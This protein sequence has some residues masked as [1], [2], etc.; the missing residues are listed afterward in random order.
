M[1]GRRTIFALCLLLVLSAIGASAETLRIGLVRCFKGLS[2]VSVSSSSDLVV[3]DQSGQVVE[4]YSPGESVNLHK[5]SNGIAI[6][7]ESGTDTAQSIDEVDISSSTP[8]AQISVQ[9]HKGNAV[10]YRGKL[11]VRSGSDGL[12]LVNVIELEDYLLGVLP[13]EMPSEFKPEAVKAQSVAA[14]TYAWAHRGRHEKQGYDLC[15]CTDCQV[16]L[17]ASGEKPAPSDAVKQ[18]TGLVASY[19]GRLISA[20]YSSDCGGIT[21]CGKEQYLA[22][23]TDRGDDGT[24]YCEHDG[25]CWSKSWTLEDFEKLI[26]KAYPNIKGITTVSI[27][28]TDKSSRVEGIKIGTGDGTMVISAVKLRSLLGNTVIKSTAFTVKL[29]SGNVVFD[30]KGFG[31]GMGLCQFGANGLASAPR[32]FTF[33]QI[34]K[35][36]YAGVEIVSITTVKSFAT[37]PSKPEGHKG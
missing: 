30:G 35:H 14:R 5:N 25:H 24:D 22:S 34:L 33:D 37:K 23:V 4:K 13:S 7:K 15:D 31:H 21:Q 12:V 11:V 29:D 8:D 10:S 32:N 27:T 28:E 2:D 26:Q 20:L 3:T 16:Y 36:Y 6:L 18:T 1:I 19:Q 17:G 9:P